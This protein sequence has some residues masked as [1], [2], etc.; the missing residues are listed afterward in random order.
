MKTAPVLH[1]PNFEK[2][3][4]LETDGSQF[5]LG[6]VLAQKE[7]SG[8]FHPIAY[9]SRGLNLHEGNYPITELEALAVVFAC[10][11]FHSYIYGQ[12][13]FVVTDHSALTFL[14]KKKNPTGRL[15]RWAVQL[16]TYQL[17]FLYRKGAENYASDALSR[18]REAY[19]DVPDL[20]DEA[21]LVPPLSRL[22]SR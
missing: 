16:A 8:K 4:Y 5:G 3:F 2:P 1:Y 11:K 20:A 19:E 6:A 21:K 22:Q 18:A 15:H 14:M 7:E 9:A 13:T 17:T 12:P 10:Q